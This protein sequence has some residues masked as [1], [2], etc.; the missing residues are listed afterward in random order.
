MPDDSNF[1]LRS[2]DYSTG[3]SC[4]RKTSGFLVGNYRRKSHQEVRI[5]SKERGICFAMGGS[6]INIAAGKEK[7]LWIRMGQ[8]SEISRNIYH[9][10]VMYD[11]PIRGERNA[12]SSEMSVPK[13]SRTAALNVEDAIGAGLIF[14]RPPLP[15]ASNLAPKARRRGHRQCVNG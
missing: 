14:G 4:Q 13:P 6:C 12:S 7:L 8:I 15:Q 10:F 2:R 11:S 5:A 9:I 3:C 1:E